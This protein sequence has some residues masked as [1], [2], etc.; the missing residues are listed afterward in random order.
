MPY[1]VGCINTARSRPIASCRASSPQR[2]ILQAAYRAHWDWRRDTPW[3]RQR[4]ASE[5]R[6]VFRQS[7]GHGYCRTMFACFDDRSPLGILTRDVISEL[8]R[9]AAQRRHPY[10]GELFAA[11]VALQK[12][13]H[14]LIDLVGSDIGRPPGWREQGGPAVCSSTREIPTL[15]RSA[16]LATRAFVWGW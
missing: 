7:F 3:R 6:P 4:R 16:H 5:C 15:P 11:V 1:I 9:G 12:I 14:P 10:F 13:I 8:S 2:C